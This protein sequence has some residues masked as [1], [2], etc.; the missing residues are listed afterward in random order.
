MLC[1]IIFG[2]FSQSVYAD[3]KGISNRCYTE[4]ENY[5]NKKNL[6]DLSRQ[7]AFDAY[8]RTCIQREGLVYSSKSNS[9]Q[10]GWNSSSP[11][12]RAC[13]P[14]YSN[15]L[16]QQ[17][18]IEYQSSMMNC[19][20]QQQAASNKPAVNAATSSKTSSVKTV[21]SSS[22]GSDNKR[23]TAN[24]GTNSNTSTRSNQTSRNVNKTSAQS[25]QP[26]AQ[27]STANSCS[28]KP[29][30]VE[31]CC[32]MENNQVVWAY[33]NC[34]TE[35]QC[36]ENGGN[37]DGGSCA[38]ATAMC[39]RDTTVITGDTQ[40]CLCA[41]GKTKV[42][43]YGAEFCPSSCSDDGQIFNS[44][45]KQCE[46]DV[47][48]GYVLIY[49]SGMSSEELYSYNGSVCIKKDNVSKSIDN[50]ASS[51]L[52]CLSGIKARVESCKTQAETAVKQC[53]SKSSSSTS[54]NIVSG[55]QQVLQA[56]PLYM[57]TK[58]GSG[59]YQNC[60]NVGLASQ[61]GYYALDR[62]KKTCS[63]EISKCSSSCEDVKNDLENNQQRLYDNCMN[64][65]KV[66]SQ[67]GGSNI[68]S[69]ENSIQ[70]ANSELEIEV[71][72]QL[73]QLAES[74]TESTGKCDPDGQ[75]EENKNTLQNY[76]SDINNTAA[77][78]NQCQCQLS[79]GSTSCEAVGPAD[80]EKN[81]NL[82]GCKQATIDC[83]V[84]NPPP[85]C[86]IITD[87][88]EVSSMIAGVGGG[89]GSA[90][91]TN[92]DGVSKFAGADNINLG[93]LSGAKTTSGTEAVQADGGSPF[94]SA[95]GGGGGLGGGPG[96]GSSSGS[97]GPSGSSAEGSDPKSI[98]GFF[99]TAKSAL[100]SL[101]GNGKNSGSSLNSK[102]YGEEN[103][104]GSAIDP[105][106]W[107]PG[108]R[109]VA[110]A[111][112]NGIGGKFQDIWK[113]MSNQ[114]KRQGLQQNFIAGDK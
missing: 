21:N 58:A 67:S 36:R 42:S 7:S 9:L 75:A 93:D 80:C 37:W 81:P 85:S 114:Y 32:Q 106:K 5:V 13:A 63:S 18:N 2:F 95:Q 25:N 33:E 84:S 48:K 112:E 57:Q 92:T 105:S 61:T 87:N 107:R 35:S 55:L 70:A 4:S 39:P 79:A 100:S 3:N 38:Q 8:Y 82:A 24:A 16:R 20:K 47:S 73:Q 89:G 76:M 23:S 56:A 78:A 108:V 15:L 50:Q 66:R 40:N 12:A 111:N 22:N 97:G 31:G 96:G 45:S 65:L 113:T 69:I 44:Q 110:A 27:N 46:C 11:E 103:G 99:N 74:V 101:F 98:G 52:K 51:S 90:Q 19:I 71:K 49:N 94:G 83:S 104:A 64:E 102:T 60:L 29:S 30:G 77:Q 88:K 34:G 86:K 72:S 1:I 109:G 43:K 62:L 17:K 10:V 54:N 41:D 53:D 68:Q 59:A 91:T 28:S 26:A 6:K 14:K